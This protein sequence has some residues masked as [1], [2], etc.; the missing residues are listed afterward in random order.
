M[1]TTAHIL[2]II[3]VLV[4]LAGCTP[5]PTPAP[6]AT[7]TPPPTATPTPE[8]TPTPT[9]TPKPLPQ[10][11]PGPD[12]PYP[13]STLTRTTLTTADMDGQKTAF[14]DLTKAE[15][16]VALEAKALENQLKKIDEKITT[17]GKVDGSR[18]G[19]F[20]QTK[21][22]TP[23]IL[24][25]TADGGKTWVNVIDASAYSELVALKTFDPDNY[26]FVPLNR[27][28]GIPKDAT[29]GVIAENNWMVYVFRDTEGSIIAWYDAANDVFKTAQGDELKLQ[30]YAY[31]PL[32]EMTTWEECVK[33]RLPNVDDPEFPRAFDAF[34]K[35][36]TPEQDPDKFDHQWRQIA[37]EKL[38]FFNRPGAAIYEFYTTNFGVMSTSTD[39]H[40]MILGC[41][42][43]DNGLQVY[44]F[45]VRTIPGEQV[46]EFGTAYVILTAAF[47]PVM[48]NTLWD[49]KPQP[50]DYRSD[51]PFSAQFPAMKDY[52]SIYGGILTSPHKPV[53]SRALTDPLTAHIAQLIQHNQQNGA[54]QAFLDLLDG[55]ITPESKKILEQAIFPAESIIVDSNPYS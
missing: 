39:I 2:S 14:A 13:A 43:M 31:K 1:K 20:A 47:D 22:G 3:I 5:A 45:Y 7:P 9:A 55:K 52:L 23:L 4:L 37:G 36:T 24:Q 26:R 15:P 27:P 11:M 34:I 42:T 38:Q 29:T 8:P 18:W 33:Q 40:P 19:V 25:K 54:E 16:Y 6:T 21:D 35:A 49:L 44:R 10:G 46:S 50:N 28:S 17:I 30:E 12:D 32:S 48:F 53:D 51:L 41:A